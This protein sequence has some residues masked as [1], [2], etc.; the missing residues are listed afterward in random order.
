MKTKPQQ[1]VLN[2]SP[3]DTA[4]AKFFFPLNLAQYEKTPRHVGVGLIH[5]ERN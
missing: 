3:V 1:K 5:T 2:S 4:I